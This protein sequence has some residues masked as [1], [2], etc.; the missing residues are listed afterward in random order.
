MKARDRRG[1]TLIELLVVIAII[2]VL[3]ALLLPAVQQAREAARR[4]QCVNN[5]KQIGI[6]MHNYHDTAGALP[7]GHGPFGWN[8]WNAQ[9][10]LLPYMEQ[11]QVYNSI[12]FS[13]GI[14]GANPGQAPNSTAQRVQINAFVCP[15]DTNR[16]TTVYGTINYVSN[17]GSNVQFFG[18]GFNG[19]FG[20]VVNSNPDRSGD[21]TSNLYRTGTSINFRDVIDGLSMTAAFSEKVR[22]I[23]ADNS[24][25]DSLN[26]KA[27]TFQYPGTAPTNDTTGA[28]TEAN[29]VWVQ[30]TFVPSCRT[31]NP[32]T[33]P[34]PGTQAYG[35]HWW[36][37]HPY[38]GR[39]NHVMLPNTNSCLYSINGITNGNGAMP[40][41]SR[42][43]GIVN[44]LFGDGTVRAVKTT[45]NQQVWWAIGSRNGAEVV[46]SDAL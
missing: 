32:N 44:I 20:W 31:V 41:N 6:A 34:L 16:I 11:A 24:T 35:Q 12:N 39:Y 5:M 33:D 21:N 10:M 18:S 3:I 40:P 9:T 29:L 15:S 23:G 17:S 36:T 45:V 25:R 2:G 1:F 8:D 4:I 26:P 19:M 14:S 38:A 37:G 43:P 42:H 27:N 13:N 22:G 46:S 7:F 28:A 30:Q